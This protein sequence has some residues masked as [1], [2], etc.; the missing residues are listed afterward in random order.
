MAISTNRQHTAE[1]NAVP[2]NQTD[3]GLILVWAP[4]AWAPMAALLRSLVPLWAR[5]EFQADQ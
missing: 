4:P 3:P 1:W 2:T 5:L